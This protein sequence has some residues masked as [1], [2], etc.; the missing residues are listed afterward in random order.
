[1]KTKLLLSALFG[2]AAWSLSSAAAANWDACACPQ[3]PSGP[4]PCIEIVDGGNVY[5]FNGS[6][7]HADEWHGMPAALGGGPIQFTGTN[8]ALDCPEN[9][10]SCTLTLDGQVKKCE[11]SNGDWRIGVRVTGADVS[12]G[13]FLCDFLNVGGFP[14]YSKDPTVTPHCPFEDDCDTFIP[15]D[16]S[17][18]SYV[19]NFG[20]VDVSDILGT[21]YVDNEHLHNVVFTPNNLGGNPAN[22]NFSNK[23][24]YNCDEEVRCTIDGI[25]Y[26]DGADELNVY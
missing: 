15:Y 19:G 22:F 18:S 2:M 12:A 11:D 24:F 4:A 3:P 1:M 17:G 25:L 9:S 8:V 6:G 5:H 20:S 23:T 10:V 21:T 26:L 7:G 16:P 13:D 14:W